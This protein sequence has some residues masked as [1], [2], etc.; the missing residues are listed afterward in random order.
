MVGMLCFRNH[1]NLIAVS[2]HQHYHNSDP[3]RLQFIQTSPEPIPSHSEVMT[4]L[5]LLSSLSYSEL[6]LTL[7]SLPLAYLMSLLFSNHRRISTRTLYSSADI[8]NSD[9]QLAFQGT[10]LHRVIFSVYYMLFHVSEI[11]CSY[12]LS[13]CLSY[14]VLNLNLA[15]PTCPRT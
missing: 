14:P 13:T 2:D 11:P 6:I 7:S 9:P 10:G 5:S 12:I 4:T 15:P 8:I 1:V 3:K